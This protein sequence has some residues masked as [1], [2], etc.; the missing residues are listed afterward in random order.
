MRGYSYIRRPF[1]YVTL[2]TL[3]SDGLAWGVLI[4]GKR[5]FSALFDVCMHRWHKICSV[6]EDRTLLAVWEEC[7]MSAVSPVIAQVT[8]RIQDRSTPERS[9]YLTRVRAAQS[10]QPQ[11]SGH[12]CANLS[13]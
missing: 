2:R 3:V 4:P 8:E 5:F 9:A 7:V 11:R 10:R 1:C 12:V 13:R 6:C